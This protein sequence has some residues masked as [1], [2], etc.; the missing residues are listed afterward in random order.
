[1]REA[2]RSALCLETLRYSGRWE[3]PLSAS[4]TG[5]FSITRRRMRSKLLFEK[6]SWSG[7]PLAG[8]LLQEGIWMQ[9]ELCFVDDGERHGAVRLRLEPAEGAMH[10]SFRRCDQADWGLDAWARKVASLC[11]DG[12]DLGLAA[13]PSA[14]PC[15]GCCCPLPKGCVVMACQA[16]DFQLCPLCWR[17]ETLAEPRAAPTT[18]PCSGPREQGTAGS[19]L[20][21]MECAEVAVEQGL[22]KS[23]F[24]RRQRIY[25]EVLL[26]EAREGCFTGIT[27][28]QQFVCPFAHQLPSLQV[29]SHTF[30]ILEI[31]GGAMYLCVEP[32]G[33]RLELTLGHGPAARL[34][35]V[36]F[37]VRGV[38]RPES[39]AR[40]I[41]AQRSHT[42]GPMAR[43]PRM[44]VGALLEWFVGPLA[45]LWPHY[46]QVATSRFHT[47][48]L[49]LLRAGAGARCLL[50]DRKTT[51]AAVRRDGRLL[52]HAVPALRAD[53]EV[54]LAAVSQ[55]GL[56]LEHAA[57]AL[58][59][60]RELV[61]SALRSDARALRHA[62][63]ELKADR[64]FMLAAVCSRR[65]RASLVLSQAP[66]ELR[67]DRDFMRAAIER[68]PGLL[69]V[70]AREVR[71]A[72]VLAAWRTVLPR[73]AT[74]LPQRAARLVGAA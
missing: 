43:L 55:S 5:S 17:H 7:R 60:Q 30:S 61:L 14:A 20:A 24:V 52:Q 19:L 21:E 23:C 32:V 69:R 54:V 18:W 67:A 28:F 15:D 10:L 36:M 16:C 39:S 64:D 72:V 12:H 9:A 31:D 62:A 3:Y 59:A 38:E 22:G 11:P 63:P 66:P 73:R 51:L 48:L 65:T 25:A 56:A 70:A 57:P 1:M 8:E 40:P 42:L 26:D 46:R 68:E 44:T 4:G 74:W 33:G 49:A 13:Q 34:Y 45:A 58:R 50:E 53:P 35:M 71:Q 47:D 2:L 37:D 41:L 29:P 27:E 6:E